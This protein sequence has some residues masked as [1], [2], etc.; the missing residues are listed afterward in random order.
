MHL[1][2]ILSDERTHCSPNPSTMCFVYPLRKKIL[3]HMWYYQQD[4][5]AY[6]TPYLIYIKKKKDTNAVCIKFLIRIL[7]D[8]SNISGG[9][10]MI[11]NLEI[12]YPSLLSMQVLI[13]CSSHI[14]KIVY[15]ISLMSTMNL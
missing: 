10:E 7:T 14:S 9:A 3:V 6:L 5:R 11:W 13:H 1:S 4:I 8:Q 12:L 2:K 15:L